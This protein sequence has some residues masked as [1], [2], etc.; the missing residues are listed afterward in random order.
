VRPQVLDQKPGVPADDVRG[1]HSEHVPGK[2]RHRLAQQRREL[3]HLVGL[4]ADQ[5][6]GHD[7]RFAVAA[8]ASR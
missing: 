1:V 6:L 7:H 2:L 4:R 8:A 3:R 5:P